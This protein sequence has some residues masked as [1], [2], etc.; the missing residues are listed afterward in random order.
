MQKALIVFALASL[1]WGADTRPKVRAI[2]AFVH[3]DARTYAAEIENT[4]QFLNGAREAYRAA[5]FEVEGVRIVTQPFTQYIAGMKREEALALF[6]KLDELSTK[7]KYAPNI[8]TAMVGDNDD[9]AVLD[10]L[11]TVLATTRLNASLIVAGEDGVHWRAIREAAKLIKNTAERSSHGSGNFN[12]AVT[13]MV[14]PYGP[15]YPGA[16]HLGAGKT[17]AV[18]LEGANVVADVFAQYHEPREA[19]KQLAAALARHMKDA[20]AVATKVAGTSGWAYAGIDPTPAPLGDVSIGRAIESFTGGPFGSSGTMTAAGIITRAV[21]SVPVKRVG[22]SGLMVPVLEDN[23]LAKRW[24][25]GTYNMDSLLAYSAVCAGGLDTVPLPG[26]TS[27]EQIA[28]IL[29]DVATLAYKWQK[30]LAARLLP[31][32]GKKAGDH[33]EFEDARMANTV[34]H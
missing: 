3:I 25:E 13:A 9:T 5:G 6:H 20:E 24:A 2:T 1:A 28:R 7:L 15:F 26:D 19:E 34:I 14:K 17:F 30:P 18:G 10:L 8:G 21:Q 4:M 29:G 12:F 31:V 22:Y 32:P 16:Y 33:T 27:V 23:L 11:A